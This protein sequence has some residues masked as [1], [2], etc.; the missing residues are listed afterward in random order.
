MDHRTRVS[1]TLHEPWLVYL[2]WWASDKG[3]L[4]AECARTLLEEALERT[5]GLDGVRE[6]Y[7]DWLAGAGDDPALVADIVHAIETAGVVEALRHPTAPAAIGAGRAARFLALASAW[8]TD[9]RPESEKGAAPRLDAI[10]STA[11]PRADVGAALAAAGGGDGL[12]IRA[13][14]RGGRQVAS[15]KRGLSDIAPVAAGEGSHEWS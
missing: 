13:A 11:I 15:D 2:R 3:E 12:A 14:A 5:R 9:A 1:V 6:R 7:E 8:L 10:L 4:P